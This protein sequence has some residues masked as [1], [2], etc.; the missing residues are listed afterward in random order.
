MSSAERQLRDAAKSGQLVD[1][2]T[3]IPGEDDVTHGEKWG[4]ERCIRARALMASLLSSERLPTG[5]RPILHLA[6]AKIIGRL[7]FAGA[8]VVKTLRLDQCY[9]EEV[10]DFTDAQTR[11]I[12]IVGSRLPGLRALHVRID[13]QLSL[14]RT[15]VRGRVGL[16]MGHIT[17]EFPLNGTRL[18]NPEDWTLFAGGLAVD[19]GLFARHGFESHGRMRLVGAHL[20]GGAFLEQANLIVTTGDAF[21]ADNLRVEG[22]MVCEGLKA[23]GAIRMPGARINGQLSWDGATVD[24][25]EQG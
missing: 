14:E 17:S 10:P 23:N 3:G 12:W 4:Q 2:R 5:G 19:G 15:V 1:L 9:L 11:S 22:R 24:V 18:I 25:R 7:D 21:V 13:G 8:D 20:N 16:V 6:G